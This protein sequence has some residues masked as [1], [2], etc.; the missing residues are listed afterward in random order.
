MKIALY[1][2]KQIVR[3]HFT[4]FA[5]IVQD[6]CIGNTEEGEYTVYTLGTLWYIK[7]AVLYT[8]YKYTAYTVV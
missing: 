4:H 3:L 6:I 5:Q 7:Y 2:R 1:N 8:L